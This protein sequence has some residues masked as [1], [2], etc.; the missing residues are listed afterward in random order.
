[1]E[2]PANLT[3]VDDMA[4]PLSPDFFTEAILAERA[5][6]EKHRYPD[7]NTIDKCVSL[8]NGYLLSCIEKRREVRGFFKIC[9]SL[10]ILDLEPCLRH[11]TYAGVDLY[12]PTDN[13]PGVYCENLR[14]ILRDRFYKAGWVL[15]SLSY[16]TDS[17]LEISHP[18][19]DESWWSRIKKWLRREK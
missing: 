7:E 13:Y 9:S 3:K 4:V 10:S 2:Q 8:I 16:Q 5:R 17:G 6:L 11:G 12:V 14:N 15:E 18:L 19:Y 1:M